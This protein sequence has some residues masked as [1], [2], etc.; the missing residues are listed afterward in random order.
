MSNFYRR[1]LAKC[2]KFIQT[3]CLL[4]GRVGQHP[5]GIC[6]N[7]WA[8]LPPPPPYLQCETHLGVWAGG[9]YWPPLQGILQKLKYQQQHHTVPFCTAL[10]TRAL[11]KAP[12]VDL[13]LA[14]PLHRQRLRDRGFNQSYL[15]AHALHREFSLP[16]APPEAVIRTQHH[17][18]LF[19]LKRQARWALMQTMFQAQQ[20]WHGERIAI[21]DDIFTTGASSYHLA[22]CLRAAGAGE[23]SIWVVARG[24]SVAQDLA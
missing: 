17:P 14:M 2:S 6:P 19:G 10:L 15:L 22:A 20:T 21:V 4:C 9:W 16:L 23:I 5:Q 3:P 11:E 7:C 13:L 12:A 18:P 1:I 8:G 24:F